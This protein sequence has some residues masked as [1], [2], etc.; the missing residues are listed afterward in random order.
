MGLAGNAACD[1]VRQRQLLAELFDKLEW[2]GGQ[3]RLIRTQEP[4]NSE[5]GGAESGGD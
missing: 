3:Q 1:A 5:S 4:A 2:D